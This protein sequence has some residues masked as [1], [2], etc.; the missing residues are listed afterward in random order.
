MPNFTYAAFS[1]VRASKLGP[2]PNAPGLACRGA[3]LY[4]RIRP[5]LSVAASRRR[6]WAMRD[7][8]RF[9]HLLPKVYAPLAPSRPGGCT[10][11]VVPGAA[12]RS[13]LTASGVRS[14]A[15]GR[16]PLCLLLGSPVPRVRFFSRVALRGP[17][18]SGAQDFPFSSLSTRVRGREAFCEAELRLYGVLGSSCRPRL[19][20]KS[21]PIHYP[22]SRQEDPLR[23]EPPT[24]GLP[25][26]LTSRAR[27]SPGCSR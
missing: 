10:L 17:A 21:V 27:P 11:S 23:G 18:L 12:L 3:S 6:S 8:T 13:S 5:A 2:G 15:A 14:L 7:P 22:L 24:Q 26:G 25:L 9:F 4:G 16:F 19:T 1:E 20:S